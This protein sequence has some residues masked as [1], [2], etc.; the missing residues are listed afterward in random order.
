[1]A[2]IVTSHHW[3]MRD[4]FR[5]RTGASLAWSL[6]LLPF[7]TILYIV[8]V[9]IDVFHPY[10]WLL[11]WLG[12]A[13]S[14]SG[15]GYIILIA[16][17]TTVVAIGNVLCYTV[18]PTVHINRLS[19]I[20]GLVK[21]PSLLHMACHTLAGVLMACCW[22]ALIGTSYSNLTVTADKGA[23]LCLND[24]HLF[25]VLHG[26][27][28]GFLYSVS[29]IQQQDQYM[30]FPVIQQLKFFQVKTYMWCSLQNNAIRSLRA[31]GYFYILF[32]LFGSIPKTWLQSN[33]NLE[34]TPVPLN[35]ISGLL[36]VSLLWIVLWTG[37]VTTHLWGV[38]LFLFKIF[39]TEVYQFPIEAA[40]VGQEERRLHKALSERHNLLVKYLAYQDLSS[41]AEHRRDRRAD[42]FALSQPGGHPHNWI[43]ICG[44]CL[45][46]IESLTQRLTSHQE[47]IANGLAQKK[48]S[49]DTTPS[50]PGGQSSNGSMAE[51]S[52]VGGGQSNQDA[53]TFW[54]TPREPRGPHLRSSVASPIT[55]GAPMYDHGYNTV[56]Q[57]PQI[58]SL[59]VLQDIGTPGIES[60][61]YATPGSGYGPLARPS[62]HRDQMKRSSPSGDHR[63]RT[64]L[65][66]QHRLD[67]LR[68]WRLGAYLLNPLPEAMSQALFT[69]VQLHIWALEALSSLVTASYQEDTYGV[70]Q[71][72]LPEILV[73]MLAVQNALEKHFKLPTSLPKRNPSD[74]RPMRSGP[75][76]PNDRLRF[77]LRSTVMT[78]LYRVVAAFGPH[79]KNIAMAPEYKRKL[80]HL[81]DY[82]Q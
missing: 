33:L 31:S 2:R 79:L 45:S 64:M 27:F 22:A 20:W 68:K 5:W 69:D 21:P 25:L 26:A 24:R 32:Y 50:E 67:S 29:Y 1:M 77:D 43:S 40:F 44:A 60:T 38:S 6:I 74:F 35:S 4:V 55:P 63:G 46:L 41:L 12:T 70:V 52:R 9:K 66:W 81:M 62:I 15:F 14:F 28:M 16:I 23:T 72:K 39:N 48:R 7:T 53:S 80:G 17:L 51:G 65:P 56:L 34:E 73:C 3:Y 13:M 76:H 19:I 18:V 58:T 78:S 57:T 36:D 75:I 8:L 37:V 82:K 71:G 49:Q 30:D 61:R 59:D 54:Y 47:W 42:V 11:D 10:T